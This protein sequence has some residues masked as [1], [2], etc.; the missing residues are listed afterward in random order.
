LIIAY[1]LLDKL[2]G[3]LYEVFEELYD[4]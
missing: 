3:W 2:V 1:I 4:F